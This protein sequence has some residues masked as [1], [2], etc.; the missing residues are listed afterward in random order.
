MSTA[1]VSTP[2][3]TLPSTSFNDLVS[4]P[5]R[6]RR[7]T[8][9]RAAMPS[10]QLTSDD[11][12]NFISAKKCRPKQTQ[13]ARVPGKKSGGKVMVKKPNKTRGRTN[14]NGDKVASSSA[15]QCPVCHIRENEP[16]DVYPWIAC[17][18]CQSWFHEPCGEQYGILDDDNFTCQFCFQS[19]N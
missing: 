4:V 17:C 5:H 7:G 12:V 1:A 19:Q 11:H 8:K 3:S 6:E 2:L 10:Y 14:G 18:V 15:V 16:K 9:R 13:K